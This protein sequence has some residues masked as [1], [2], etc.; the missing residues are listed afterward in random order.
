MLVPL[1]SCLSQSFVQ[2]PIFS[3]SLEITHNFTWSSIQVRRCF[4]FHTRTVETAMERDAATSKRDGASG[5]RSLSAQKCKELKTSLFALLVEFHEHEISRSAKTE[6]APTPAGP[7]SK[8]VFDSQACQC[9]QD[10]RPAY[11]HDAAA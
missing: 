11:S 4:F 1:L 10:T 8:P 2:T 3:I 7:C 6:T 9:Q 5:R